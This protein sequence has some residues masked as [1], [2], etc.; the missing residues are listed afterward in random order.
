MCVF[1]RVCV[2]CCVWRNSSLVLAVS[3]SSGSLPLQ[4]VEVN[5]IMEPPLL[6]LPCGPAGW[7]FCF[8]L[9]FWPLHPSFS[10]CAV[11]VFTLHLS[12]FLVYNF[13]TF[14][15]T[16]LCWNK[17]LFKPDIIYKCLYM[18]RQH[19]LCFHSVF[20]GSFQDMV[21][22]F[23]I[24]PKSG[25]KEVAPSYVFMLWYEFCTDFKNTWIRQNKNISKER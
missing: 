12:A 17:L 6:A 22:Y 19:Y 18:I 9:C 7:T 8:Q 14:R 1:V 5:V 13:L 4:A 23:G 16:V 21:S 2:I 3:V 25:E 11:S 10:V 24:K 20:P 15:S